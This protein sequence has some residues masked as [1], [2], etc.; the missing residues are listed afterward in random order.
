MKA[1]LKEENSDSSQS[2][3]EEQLVSETEIN[4]S[5]QSQN[6]DFLGNTNSDKVIRDNNYLSTSQ[7][8]MNWIQLSDSGTILG[9]GCQ[10]YQQDPVKLEKQNLFSTEES[11]NFFAVDQPPTL[12]WYFPEQ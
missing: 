11:C 8:L 10:V 12:H 4:I 6:H 3:K 1:K 7:G 9:N 5:V 2:V